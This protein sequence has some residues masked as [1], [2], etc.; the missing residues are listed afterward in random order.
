[1]V[2]ARQRGFKKGS[3]EPFAERKAFDGRQ[4]C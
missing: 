4:F 2:W 1:V 3:N